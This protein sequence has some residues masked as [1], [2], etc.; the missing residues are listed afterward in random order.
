LNP[1]CFLPQLLGKLVNLHGI[2]VRLFAELV[3]DQLIL[4]AVGDGRNR[5]RVSRKVVELCGSLVFSL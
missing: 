4:F 3:S 1:R 5:V 2:L